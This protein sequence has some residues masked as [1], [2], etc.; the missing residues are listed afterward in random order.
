M[1]TKTVEN[2]PNSMSDREKTPCP[3]TEAPH[4]SAPHRREFDEYIFHA[5]DARH[6]W[7]YLGAHTKCDPAVDG[8]AERVVFRVWAPHARSVAVVGSF[9]DWDVGIPMTRMT[10]NGIYLLSLPGEQVPDGSIYKYRIETADRQIYLRSDP[11]GR[12]MECPPN[13][14]TCFYRETSFKWHDDGWLNQRKARALDDRKYPFNIYELHAGS[15]KRHPDGTP[16]SYRELADELAPYVKQMGY[17]HVELMP[18]MEHPFGGSWGYQVCGYYAP[19]ARFGTPDDFRAFVDILHGAGI[20][21]ILDWVPAHFPRDEHGLYHFDGEPLYEYSDPTRMENKNW[22]TCCF[23]V[24]RNEVISFLISNAYYWIEEFHA[25]G[26]RVDAVASMLYLDYDR[27]DGEWHPN[28]RG[29]YENLESIAFFRKLNLSLRVDHPDV[30][31]IAEESTMWA[32]IT[33]LSENGLGFSYKWNMGWMNDTL[34]YAKEDPLF[35]KYHH[36]ML[37]HM[38]SYAFDEQYVLPISHDEVV[39]LKRSFLDKMPGDY[40]QKFAGVRVFAAWMMTHPGAKLWFMGCEIGQFAEWSD[41]RELDWFLLDHEAHARLQHYFAALNHFYLATPALWDEYPDNPSSSFEWL[42][43]HKDADSTLAYRRVARDGSD[44]VVVLNFT[45]PA[46]LGYDINVP[47]P[48]TYVEIFNSDNFEFGGSN[49][50]N[51]EPLKSFP[52]EGSWLNKITID[53]PPMGMAVFRRVSDVQPTCKTTPHKKGTRPFSQG[54]CA[55]FS[56][57]A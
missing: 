41:E 21:V 48:G 47:L 23:D 6:A 19:T 39:H 54:A 1:M 30:L 33:D 17:T 26:L 24:G 32:H 38:P 7:T 18:I 37:L 15:W 14:A 2:V 35:R 20:G 4:L 3:N 22:G 11:Y 13:T 44:I 27:G 52:V 10:D 53:L 34:R 42:E 46:R 49:V 29:G 40:W 5:G 51:R 50:L 16:L 12:A 31:T 8:G 25:D 56:P 9:A 36:G 57:D 45:P 55:G 43:M 28:H